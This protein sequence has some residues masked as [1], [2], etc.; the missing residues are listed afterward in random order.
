MKSKVCATSHK[1]IALL[2]RT[3]K[4]TQEEIDEEATMD[5]FLKWV[6]ACIH[7]KEVISHF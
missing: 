3:Q 4:K 7:E 6:K 1:A 2:Q 5:A